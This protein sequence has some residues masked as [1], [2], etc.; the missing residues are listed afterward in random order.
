MLAVI[1]PFFFATSNIT[2][3]FLTNKKG[4]EATKISFGSFFVVGAILIVVLFWKTEINP[5]YLLIGTI[6][7]VLNTL[8]L[9]FLALACSSGPVG[10]ATA[11]S[12]LHTLLF[13]IIQA[14]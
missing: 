3:K 13:T 14:F 5:T 9:T 4:F 8:G 11:L 7:S 12:N 2:A 1:A 6:G 10:P